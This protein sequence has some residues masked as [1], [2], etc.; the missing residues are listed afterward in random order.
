[1][2]GKLYLIPT[3]ISD[4]NIDWVIPNAV[5]QSIQQ[6]AYY[7]VERPK[8]ARQFLKRI[9][10]K[11]PLQDMHMDTLNEHTRTSELQLLLQPLLAGN[12]VG[13]LSEAGCPAIADPGSGLIRLAHENNIAIIPLIG[14]SSILLA[15]MASGLNGQ[16]FCF[17]G[18]LPI[19]KYARAHTIKEL[20]NRSRNHDQTQIFIEAPYRNQGLLEQ[21]I[22]TCLDHTDLCIAAHLTSTNEMIRTQTIIEWK[23]KLPDIHKTPTIFLLHG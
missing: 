7:I 12:D 4:R 9:A 16:Q 23:K 22:Q 3:P 14:P 11:T 8:T 20:E 6:L 13:L 5:R 15:L 17:N 10:C 18:Y 2:T 1:M 21:I 19:E